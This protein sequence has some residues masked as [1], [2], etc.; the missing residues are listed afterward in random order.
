MHSKQKAVF[1]DRD[2]T[3]IHHVPYLSNP[4][5]V[6]LTD[7][8]A[9]ALKKLLERNFL[10]FVLTNQ[11]G[12]GRGYYTLEEAHACNQR[13]LE[14]LNLPSP[15][16]RQI[17]IAPEAPGE[18]SLYRKPSPRFIL[19]KTEEYHLDPHLCY[20]VGDSIRDIET[21]WNAQ[22]VPIFITNPTLPEA[23]KPNES[24]LKKV[25]SYKNL[26]EWVNTI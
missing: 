25:S 1:F 19:E 18:P 17:Q 22:I 5:Q 4:N 13:M 9:E 16:I 14:L 10:L 26:L 23:E 24:T 2:G 7:G 21:A 20:M 12:V 15:G 8:C 3:L 6:V 11:S